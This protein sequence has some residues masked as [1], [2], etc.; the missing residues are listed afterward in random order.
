V[1]RVC[2]GPFPGERS[3]SQLLDIGP[4]ICC[5]LRVK[6]APSCGLSRWGRRYRL[7]EKRKPTQRTAHPQGAWSGCGPPASGRP[8]GREGRKGAAAEPASCQDCGKKVVQNTG[9]GRPR[10]YCHA[11]GDKTPA[12]HRRWRANRPRYRKCSKC[13]QRFE[14]EHDGQTACSACTS[15]NGWFGGGQKL[16]AGRQRGA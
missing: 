2:R 9:R 12:A 4:L 1:G 6:A 15:L 14:V 5:C 16:G 10:K 13:M 7:E 3:P 11:C 8:G